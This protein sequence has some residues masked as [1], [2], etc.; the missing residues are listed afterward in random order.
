MHTPVMR[1]TL[2]TVRLP[3][4][5]K[6]MRLGTTQSAALATKEA[7]SSSVKGPGGWTLQYPAAPKAKR[8]RVRKKRAA[9]I[10]ATAAEQEDAGLEQP[11]EVARVPAGEGSSATSP[12]QQRPSGSH[13]MDIV[14]A[15]VLLEPNGK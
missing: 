3:A 12:T 2:S 1:I 5:E 7:E 9:V 8:P 14:D 4:L 11:G 13:A 6:A 10:Q 15:T